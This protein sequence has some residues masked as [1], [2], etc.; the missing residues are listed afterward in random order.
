MEEVE[1]TLLEG[2]IG[3]LA[4]TILENLDTDMLEA[5][6]RQVG[7]ADDTKKL[8]SEIERVE[9]VVA[10]VKG[11]A[12]GNRSLARSLGSLRELL[13]DADDAVDELDYCRLEQ[14]VQGVT[15]N[16][17]E[18]TVGD[19]TEHNE[20]DPMEMVNTDVPT[21]SKKRSKAWEHFTRL[22]H[23]NGEAPKA[24]CKYC[25]KELRCPSTNGTSVLHN[26]IRI[27]KRY[28]EAS[29]QPPNISSAGD[30]APN[31][32]SVATDSSVRRKRRRTNEESTQHVVANTWSKAVFSNR[33][34]QITR[35]LQGAI[36]DVLRLHGSDAFASSNLCRSTTSDLHLMTSS[37]ITRKLYGRVAD[38][39]SII[40]LMTEDSDSVTILPIVG[41]GGIGKTALAQHIYNDP[42]VE[43]QFQH[44]IWVCVSNN[45]DEVRLTREMLDFVC[46]D[47]NEG[48]YSFAK[49]QES[50]MNSIKSKR[51]LLILDDVWDNMNIFRWN[52][53]LAPLKSN[54][55]KGNIIL[56]T[57][58][59]MSVAKR[60]G[61]VEAIKI[62][63][64]DKMDFWQLFIACAFG[65]E[66]YKAHKCLSTIAGQIAY[67]LK[68]NPLAAET[69]G[70]L[71]NRRHTVDHWYNILKNEDWKS[72]QLNG[73]IMPSLKL[74]YD[75]LPSHLQ[76][77]FLYCSIFPCDYRFVGE[78]LVRTWTS[79][80][81]LK[82]GHSNRRMEE[83]GQG[84][85]FDLVNLGFIELVEREEPTLRDQ[86]CY[87]M[88]GLMHDF[89]R[90]VSRTE[91]AT[92]DG[93]QC[94]KMAP[95]IR[96]LSIL[97]DSTYQRDPCN[98]K[99]E[100]MIKNAVPLLRNLRMLVLIGKYAFSVS[101]SIK[102]IVQKAQKLRLLQV[103]STY[104]HPFGQ[105]CNQ[106]DPLLCN[107]VNPTHIRYIKIDNG[108]LPQSLRIFYH[109]QVLDACSKP[110]LIMPNDMDN[111]VSLRHLVAPEQ[112]YMSIASIS[113]MTALQELHG[114]S[115]QVDSSSETTLLQSMN[116]LVQLGVS[117]LEN[118]T[119]RAD[120]SGA[121]LRDK[122]NLERLRL[123]W[124]QSLSQDKYE[125]AREVLEGLEPHNNLKHLQ[126]SWYNGATSPTWLA[127]SLTSLQTLRLVYCGHW[128]IIPSLERLPF[129]RKMELRSMQNVVEIQ[130]PPLEEL[131]LFEMPKLERCS[132]TSMRDL[133]SSLRVL[134]IE[135]C[136]MLKVF[137][138]FEDCQQFEIE[139]T[140]WLSHLSKLTIHNCP[141]LHVHNPLP[142]SIS[143][144]KLSIINVPTLP[145]FEGSSSGTLRIKLPIY[146]NYILNTTSY[147]L[148][149]LDDKVLSFHNLRFLTGLKLYGSQNRTS[150]SFEGLRQLN[151]L[152]SLEL[153]SFRELLF[154]N[155]PSELTCEDTSGANR[156]AFRSLECLEICVCGITEKWLSLMLQHAQA[157]HY[158]SLHICNQIRGLSIGEEENSQPNPI[159]SAAGASSLGYPGRDE[160]LCLS[161]NLTPSLKKVS[162][163][164]CVDFTF[165]GN[166]EGFAGFT[167]LEELKIM[168][169]PKLLSS[170][171]Q[172]NGRW[173]LPQSLRELEIK[174]NYS[175]ETLQPCFPENLT[176]LKKLE[177]QGNTSLTS[178]RLHSCTA[179]Q[180][181]IIG[182][183]K[184]LNSLEGLQSLGNLRLL[185]AYKCFGDHRE[186]GR[187]L[188]LQSLE[189]LYVD[190]Y[191]QETLQP[192]F[193]RNLT[194]LKGLEVSYTESL[195][196]LKLQSCTALEELRIVFCESL[197]A[198][199][200]LQSLRGIRNLEIRGC[201]GLPPCLVSL[202]GQGYELCPGLERLH[203]DD[204]SV[205]TTSFCKH[206]ALLQ[207]L[208]LFNCGSEVERLT[209]EQERA[210]QLL[211]SLQELRFERCD[212]LIDLPT[213]LHSLPSLKR[214]E[215]AYCRKITKLP[216]KGIPPSL[217]ELDITGS[218]KELAH[219]C[220]TLAS[221]LKVK[222]GEE[223]V[224]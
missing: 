55:A 175:I 92:I 7:L 189:E 206:L 34:Q 107:Q 3:W 163:S 2:G 29:D 41:I 154:S 60:I 165:Y 214:L 13:Y 195:K 20:D 180:E 138:L 71:L 173:L 168:G 133:N 22:E 172:A 95:T 32:N 136:P 129:L 67:K 197:A 146:F 104:T 70:E 4:E 192:C 53:L 66:K 69:A 212:N 169:C 179:L 36:S 114:F 64:L 101:Q 201:P 218:S 118:I 199:E 57:T 125:N 177:V 8:R 84:Y 194:C 196:Y 48:L 155:V 94:N 75:Q 124:S 193:P 171:V 120:A 122:P 132:C 15:W 27:C 164:Y 139:R 5:W 77:C 161:L 50:L 30:G 105:T 203:I 143:V 11:K 117:Q 224:Y 162:I 91:Y 121:R 52:N 85:L 219:Q 144:S 187:H 24:R 100:E 46:Q 112:M 98:E 145:T 200:G 54:N 19:G 42:T 78:E 56:V 89:A 37:L 87:A 21:G 35:H 9:G 59:S 158:L 182:G 131:M 207:C 128:Q 81:F 178:L 14:Q 83:I 65:E 111:L 31:G 106:F 150:V 149:T 110:Y 217:E 190:E 58:R 74:S 51:F 109:L 33:I 151:C 102:D 79:Q 38:K 62:G 99:F 28:R 97:I 127:T 153:C 166:K 188:L 216:E 152:K 156:R 40:E 10:A 191:S 160:L 113:R 103:C 6:I 108:A 61:T 119:A 135:R 213:G 204:P 185:K 186:H 159:M 183:C 205:L 215:I 23:I 222:I 142:P 39:K 141:H 49:L 17:P 134:K 43:R 82:C 176:R 116:Q 147:Q 1:A 47:K 148:S 130:I 211:T 26:H 210:L 223:Y 68:G 93:L 184:W 76:R 86:T 16:E 198:I 170:L 12:M 126:I 72:L 96:H 208:H 63:A 80:G 45:F 123:S 18:D 44:R 181:L 90:M 157:L 140:S 115:V 174:Y 137:P 73:G 167:S 25:E 221:K 220:R 202:S 209:D 88:C